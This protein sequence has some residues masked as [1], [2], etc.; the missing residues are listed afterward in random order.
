[1]RSTVKTSHSEGMFLKVQESRTEGTGYNSRH[2]QTSRNQH[3]MKNHQLVP[4]YWHF[5]FLLFVD[6]L[7]SR[8]SRVSEWACEMD[9]IKLLYL[10]S[11]LLLIPAV[12]LTI[13]TH[14]S[15]KQWILQ[16]YLSVIAF[17]KQFHGV[18]KSP[19]H[20]FMSPEGK[21]TVKAIQQFDFV[22]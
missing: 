6:Q 8:L 22:F 3:Q 12:S 16:D 11:V 13:P 9:K 18:A 1:M 19:V 5:S 4:G 15:S 17:E 20:S 21:G 14:L 7:S 10:L 2:Q